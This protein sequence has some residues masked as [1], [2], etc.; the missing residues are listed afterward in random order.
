M[1]RYLFNIR[2]YSKTNI[3]NYSKT[4]EKLRGYT[5]N[6]SHILAA[7]YPEL[8]SM[9]LNCCLDTVLFPVIQIEFSIFFN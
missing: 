4:A 1:H 6:I 5:S 2:N 8:S 7:Q 9:V 3:R